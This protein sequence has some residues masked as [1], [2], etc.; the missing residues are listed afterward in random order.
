MKNYI[1]D[2]DLKYYDYIIEKNGDCWSYK[3]S[4]INKCKDC[5]LFDICSKNILDPT[6]HRNM[7]AFRVQLS[8]ERLN[9]YLMESVINDINE[10]SDQRLQDDNI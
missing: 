2:K 5:P 6:S 1:N 8:K 3:P 9:K 10:A 7:M 4:S